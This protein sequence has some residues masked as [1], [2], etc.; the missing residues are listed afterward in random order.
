MLWQLP[1]KSLPAHS[2]GSH[3]RR[4][5]AGRTLEAIPSLGSVTTSKACDMIS[6]TIAKHGERFVRSRLAGVTAVSF[7]STCYPH[8]RHRNAWTSMMELM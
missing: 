1:D 5:S 4:M 7:I 8:S 2:N 6:M 3:P